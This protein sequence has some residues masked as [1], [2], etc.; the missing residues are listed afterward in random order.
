MPRSSWHKSNKHSSRDARDYSDS[1]KDS[2]LKRKKVR[3]EAASATVSKD[4]GSIEKRKHKYASDERGAK[5]SF[6]SGNGEFAIE[7]RASKSRK[8]RAVD[9]GVTTY[10][11]N[12]GERLMGEGERWRKGSEAEGVG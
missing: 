5:G 1:D 3:E 8:D 6:D 9:D 2:S 4:L 11:W 12:G 7:H 10:L